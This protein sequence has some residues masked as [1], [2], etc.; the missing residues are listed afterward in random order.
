MLLMKTVTYALQQNLHR[1]TH[2]E[3]E[4]SNL[5]V[6]APPL[7]VELD[8]DAEGSHSDCKVDENLETGST[9]RREDDVPPMNGCS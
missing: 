7:H 8:R 3:E 2:L 5:L 6:V 1:I 9:K 4:Y